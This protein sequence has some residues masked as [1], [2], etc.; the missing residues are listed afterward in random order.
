MVMNSVEW[1]VRNGEYGPSAE[2]DVEWMEV[3]GVV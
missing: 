1:G 3:K 2:G